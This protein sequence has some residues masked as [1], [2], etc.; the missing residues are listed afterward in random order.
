MITTN[1]RA[2]R[3]SRAGIAAVSA[4]S[5]ALG[6]AAVVGPGPLTLEAAATPL[7]NEECGACGAAN[8]AGKPKPE[9]EDPASSG[10][11]QSG[12]SAASGAVAE[13]C[14]GNA[15]RSPILWLLPVVLLAQTGGK[16]IEP[17]LGQLQ[18]QLD[19]LNAQIGARVQEASRGQAQSSD[20]DVPF[21]R[22]G[23]KHNWV[24]EQHGE[25]FGGIGARLDEVNGQLQGFLND[26]N[27]KQA[28]EVAG[29]I[30][31]LVAAGFIVYDWCST[32]SGDANSSIKIEG[33][34]SGSSSEEVPPR[35]PEENVEP[36]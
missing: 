14:F 19:G 11:A 13:R 27:V 36:F 32:P 30:L 18:G 35:N 9:P 20:D 7:T 8:E 24:F 5:L 25:Q 26:P 33:S 16:L 21:G 28:G 17:Y 10:P 31:P 15:V 34:S 23:N 29:A 1:W 6:A 3:T 22:T 4:V 2:R 12:L